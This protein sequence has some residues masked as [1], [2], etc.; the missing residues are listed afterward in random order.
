[1]VKREI[2]NSF[3]SCR[4][5]AVAGVSRSGK[6]F[7]NSALKELKKK[8]YT[9]YPVNPNAS[10]IEGE[11]CFN[12]LLDLREK[13]DGVVVVVPPNESLKVV[14]DAVSAGIKNIWL[15]QG[16]E[17]DEAI[18]FCSENGLNVVYGQ[19]ILMFAEPAEFFHRAHRWIRGVTGKLPA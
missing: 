19:C 6:K 18:S 12:S 7:G 15:Q 11:K 17:S 2:V 13:V 1:M 3:L 9:V 10:E 4:K 14:K 8:G 5:L 16:A